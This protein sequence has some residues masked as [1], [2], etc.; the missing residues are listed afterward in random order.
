MSQF[1][2]STIDQTTRGPDT[3]L[4]QGIKKEFQQVN[5]HSSHQIIINFLLLYQLMWLNLSSFW[6]AIPHLSGTLNYTSLI[7]VRNCVTRE[8]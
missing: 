1:K 6:A 4:S 8:F 7:V 3:F 2:I 5:S